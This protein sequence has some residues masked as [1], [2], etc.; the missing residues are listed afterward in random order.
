MRA[1]S[2]Y[3]RRLLPL[4]V[5]VP[6]LVSLVAAVVLLLAL[7]GL[8]ARV[9]VHWSA[10]GTADGYGSPAVALIA[11]PLSIGFGLVVWAVLRIP[12]NVRGAAAPRILTG[13][14]VFFG[15]VLSVVLTAT[16]LG[17]A[18]V[19]WAA[20]GS[21]VVIGVVLAVAAALLLPAPPLAGGRS[22]TAVDPL[23]L[24]AS[25]RAVWV[26]SAVPSSVVAVSLVAVAAA[27]TVLTLVLT[28]TVGPASL[29]LLVPA[30]AAGAASTGWRVRI[31]DRGAVIRGVLPPV[32][33]RIPLDELSA[34]RITTVAPVADFGGWGPRRHRGVTGLVTRAGEA[35]EFERTDGRRLLATVDGAAEAAALLTAL[36]GRR[37]RP[38]PLDR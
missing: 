32:T 19:P 25:E 35:L 14:S 22:T 27:L 30:L 18:L 21:A 10:S 6:A 34:A 2:S 12:E 13:C 38:V 7:P 24:G 33:I 9:A 23:A 5:G 8:P 29:L 1:S 15:T 4:A 28:V 20:L 31:D 37:G 36:I 17:G 11:V 16:V 26:G 3:S